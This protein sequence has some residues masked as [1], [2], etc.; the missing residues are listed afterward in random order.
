M[1]LVISLIVWT[2]TSGRYFGTLKT[3]RKAVQCLRC[4]V[5]A[6]L[7]FTITAGSTLPTGFVIDYVIVA[8]KLCS[9]VLISR[10]LIHTSLGRIT[11]TLL[12]RRLQQMLTWSNLSLAGCLC[13]T[14]ISF[15]LQYKAF[16]GGGGL[17]A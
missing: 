17:N 13:L 16:R 8:G 3:L 10:P 12:A 4:C 15:T 14:P 2:L 6:S 9:A 1:L 11:S 5:K 7:F